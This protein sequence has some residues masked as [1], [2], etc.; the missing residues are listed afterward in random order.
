MAFTER[1]GIPFLTQVQHSEW[2]LVRTRRPSRRRNYDLGV[3]DRAKDGDLAFG[4]PAKCPPWIEALLKPIDS[5]VGGQS[6]KLVPS[7]HPSNGKYFRQSALDQLL[8]CAIVQYHNVTEG[9]CEPAKVRAFLLEQC[10]RLGVSTGCI[11]ELVLILTR[12][13][14]RVLMDF[15]R[16]A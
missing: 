16:T 8:T 13:P 5:L 2:V 6:F 4:Q 7:K 10:S 15:W 14:N 12:L 11:H 1:M 9:K 3:D